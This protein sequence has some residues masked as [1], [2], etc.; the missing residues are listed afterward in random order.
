MADAGLK[1]LAGLKSLVSLYLGETQV[2]DAGLTELKGLKNLRSLDL[3]NTEVTES[4]VM[5]LRK[6]LPECVIYR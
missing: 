6:A 1:E 3:C 2:T 5:E 4:G